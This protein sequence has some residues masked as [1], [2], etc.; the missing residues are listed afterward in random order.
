MH[1]YTHKHVHTHAYACLSAHSDQQRTLALGLLWSREEVRS[2]KGSSSRHQLPAAG[3][4]WPLRLDRMPQIGVGRSPPWGRCS[5]SPSLSKQA[6]CCCSCQ[7][8]VSRRT[9]SFRLFRQRQLP[10]PGPDLSHSHCVSW[11][12]SAA[13]LRGWDRVPVTETLLWNMCP[14]SAAL[15]AGCHPH[16]NTRSW[17]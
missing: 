9:R 13:S 15:R 17:W 14:V 1:V 7:P 12:P 3:A 5:A 8:S 2:R 16:L 4:P 10:L 6:A 11:V